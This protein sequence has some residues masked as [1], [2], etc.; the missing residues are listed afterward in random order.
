MLCALWR[1]SWGRGSL[2]SD[3]EAQRQSGAQKYAR[4]YRYLLFQGLGRTA[5]S[6]PCIS[7]SKGQRWDATFSPLHKHMT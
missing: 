7:S 3:L 1:L 6:G 2:V 4:N 5:V